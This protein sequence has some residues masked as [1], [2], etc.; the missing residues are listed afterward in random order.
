MLTTCHP[1]SASVVQCACGT[2]PV[3]RDNELKAATP[4]PIK[5]FERMRVLTV[6]LYY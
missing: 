6:K 2:L 5:E 4:I 1:N 3:K